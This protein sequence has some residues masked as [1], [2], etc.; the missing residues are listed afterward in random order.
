MTS[1]IRGRFAAA[2]IAAASLAAAFSAEAQ[3]NSW[4]F[5]GDDF[6]DIASR[7]SLG[8]RPANTHLVFITNATTKTVTIDSITSGTFPASLTISNLTLTAPGSDVNTLFLDNPGTVVPLTISDA[9]TISAGGVLRILN[10][11]VAVQGS[12][13]AG[14]VNDGAVTLISGSFVATNAGLVTRI[15]YDGLGQFTLSNGFAH[16]R[17]VQLGV[18]TGSF[19]TLI[20]AGGT[21]QILGPLRVGYGF[22]ATGSVLVTGGQMFATNG[23]TKIGD[24][25]NGQMTVSNGV[26]RL[27]N[28]ALGG[29]IGTEGA[30]TVAGGTNEVFGSL[31]VGDGG[32]SIGRMLV[33]GGSFIATNTTTIVGNNG[34][35]QMTV[36]GGVVRLTSATLGSAVGSRGSLTIA[37]GTNSLTDS[38]Y[39]GLSSGATGTVLV[40]GGELTATNGFTI[41]GGSGVGQMAVSNGLWR[42]RSVDVGG[43]PGS[44]GSLL[45]AGGTNS[46]SSYLSLGT[47]VGA[48][49]TMVVTGG[50][51]NVTNAISTIGA[52]SLGQ[53]TVSN[54]LWRANNLVVG[55]RANSR[56][57]LLIAGGTNSVSSTMDIGFFAGATGTVVV[58][59]GELHVTNGVTTIGA[60][61]V[62]RMTVS[63]GLWR[64]TDVTVASES[65]SQGTLRIAGGTNL[66]AGQLTVGLAAGATGTVVFVGG[67]F[68]LTNGSTRIGQ[69]GVG[70]MT[71][72]NRQW[73]AQAVTLG[74]DAGSLGLLTVAGGTNTILSALNIGTAA[75]GLGSYSLIDGVLD[76]PAVNLNA[77]GTFGLTNGVV[78]GGRVAHNGAL[79]VAGDSQM[80]SVLT[81]EAGAQTTIDGT[82]TATAAIT[83]KGTAIGGSGTLVLSGSG[84]FVGRGVVG[85]DVINAGTVNAKGGNLNLSGSLL[86]N[87]NLLMNSVG[88]NLFIESPTVI[89]RGNVTV[90]AGGSVV[91]DAVLSN[92]AG[93]TVT[94]LGGTL[95]A[96]SLQNASNGLVSLSGG[97]LAMPF[98]NNASNGTLRGYGGLTGTLN[99]EGAVDFFG[100][101]TVAGD[102]TNRPG[103]TLQ[104]RNQSLLVS[105]V[106][107]NEGTLTVQSATLDLPGDATFTN[108][109]TM[110]GYGTWTARAIENRHTT[111]F[112]DGIANIEAAYINA[113]GTSTVFQTTANFFGAVTNLAGATL[114]LTGGFA[115]FYGS[116]YNNGIYFSDPATNTFGTLAVGPAGA[117]IGGV[118]DEFV[119]GGDFLNDSTNNMTFGFRYA[120]L[121]FQ[122][123]SHV[124][125]LAGADLGTNVAGYD[126]NFALGTLSVSPGGS[127]TLADGNPDNAGTALYVD[128]FNAS[129]QQITSAFNIYYNPSLNPSLND[130]TY[131]LA[132]GGWLIPI[133][134]PGT[135]VLL[136]MGLA[137][138]AAQRR[139]RRCNP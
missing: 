70:Q 32:F 8:V 84:S 77:R 63:N 14:V 38:L 55:L 17:D 136:M 135:G 100:A 71:V 80:D 62:G 86:V 69:G 16:L 116:F 47:L 98:V 89:N 90:N 25:G 120:G 114:K 91:F 9:L 13:G 87:S 110:T 139:R 30:L 21:N 28:V 133:P 101:T 112:E 124:F 81:I 33:T 6:W 45:I 108:A 26:V 130:Q 128:F 19:G 43:D 131:A 50:E 66:L 127:V 52:R 122:A 121:T 20:V 134:E 37:G 102:L 4:I 99:N 51:L 119:I 10:G 126:D 54:G 138:L 109:G 11:S 76:T 24:S 65:G 79:V 117:L 40:T 60:V 23:L 82:L 94:V 36:S 106:M 78:K 111:R 93:K 35:G 73:T 88:A 41:I 2:I 104:V 85:P 31:S 44:Q 97:T 53:M 3:T 132:G 75:A 137:G 5:T 95:G 15:G 7:W 1:S 27:F 105:G 125:Q 56:G 115:N 12:G 39:V 48:T 83:N 42:A 61:G 113:A 67:E 49:G 123:G 29:N 34:A 64:A 57:S 58:T 72:S 68:N 118:G 74:Q 92:E 22:D 103:A 107:R 46:L 18:N 129:T 96:A 59:G